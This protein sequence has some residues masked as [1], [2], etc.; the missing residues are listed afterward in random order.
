VRASDDGRDGGK[1]V[2]QRGSLEKNLAGEGVCGQE[3]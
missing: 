3:V 1:Q 2:K